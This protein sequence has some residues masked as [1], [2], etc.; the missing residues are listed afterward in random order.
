MMSNYVTIK[1][2][3]DGNTG[4]YG[5]LSD[6]QAADELN[7]VDKSENRASMSGSEIW[8]NTDST[9]F[10]DVGISDTKRAQW[11]ALCGIASIDPFGPAVAVATE[12]FVGVAGNTLSN[13]STAR[14]DTVSRAGQLGLSNVQPEDIRIARAQ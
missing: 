4:L 12:I 3:L 11:L 14:T 5:A 8:E 9:Q 1:A 2:E 7:T 10:N 13:L 6:A